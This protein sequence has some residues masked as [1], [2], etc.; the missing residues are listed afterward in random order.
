M[1]APDSAAGLQAER[2]FDLV[3]AVLI[4]VIAVLAAVLS[5]VQ[6]NSGQA[7]NRADLESARLAADLSARI[8]VSGEAIDSAGGLQEAALMIAIE[9]TARQEAGLQYDDPGSSAVGAAEQSAYKK[10]Q[11][12]L[13]DTSTST[14]GA[15]VDPYTSGLLNAT[16]QQLIAEVQAQNHQV[17]LANVASFSEQLAVL[18]LSFLALSGVLTGLAA[19]LRE[20]RGGRIALAAA[21]LM[22]GAAGLLALLA[23]L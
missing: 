4:G 9:A 8:A 5:V 3:A 7:A 17:D 18:G 12:S 11:A 2:R 13:A 1:I 22:S 10:L 14:G 20:S 6:M 16:T 21:C 19:V 15:P 23:F